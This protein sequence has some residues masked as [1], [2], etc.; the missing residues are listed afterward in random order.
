MS[1]DLTPQ[2]RAADDAL[3]AAFDQV[4][5]AYGWKGV[6]VAWIIAVQTMHIDE[7]GEERTSLWYQSPDG[8]SWITTIGLTRAHALLL[9]RDYTGST[10]GGDVG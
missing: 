3:Q 8:Q 1:N 9:E 7:D 6:R 10:T 4:G 5:E 2:Q